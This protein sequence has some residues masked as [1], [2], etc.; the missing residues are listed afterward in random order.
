MKEIARYGFILG[1]ICFVSSGVLAVVN[2]VTEPRIQYEKE[3][4]ERLALKEVMPDSGNF[5]EVL[6]DGKLLYY[7][8]YDAAGRLNGFAVKSEE[9]GYSST[10]EVIAGLNLNLEIINIKILSQNETP[11]LGTRITEPD[12]LGRFRGKDID[13][14]SRLDSITGATISSSAVINAVKNKI[15]EL[16]E[17][18]LKEVKNAK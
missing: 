16:K 15:L 13:S 9:K 5:E 12:F 3:K 7:K 4:E 11:G 8:T 17:Q 1:T 18:L 10:I 2:G 14:L 6:K